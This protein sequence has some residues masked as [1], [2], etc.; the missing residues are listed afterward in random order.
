MPVTLEHSLNLLSH[1]VVVSLVHLMMPRKNWHV[2]SALGKHCFEL[3]IPDTI[4]CVLMLV[5]T[6]P[7]VHA[8][9]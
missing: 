2:L 1:I 5:L 3:H 4:L 8:P 6:H 7:L 9:V